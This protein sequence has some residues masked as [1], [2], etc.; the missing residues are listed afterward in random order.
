M[1][2]AILTN[3]ADSFQKPMAEG[4]SRMFSQIGVESLILYDGLESLPRLDMPGQTEQA[5][6]KDHVRRVPQKYNSWVAYRRLIHILRE[7]DFAVIVSHVPIPYMEHF[8]DDMRLRQDVPELPIVLYDLVYLPTRGNWAKWILENNPIRVQHGSHWGL[9]RYDYH[10]C[11]TEISPLPVPPG[12]EAF[13][14]IGIN[15]ADPSLFVEPNKP[16]VALIDFERPD[17]LYER[18]VQILAC[19][20]AGIPFKV[21]HG[22]YPMDQIRAIY[23]SCSV[24]F[25]A[26]HESFG[27]PICEVQACGAAVLTP[28]A[29]WCPS[30]CLARPERDNW[31]LPRNFVVYDNDLGKLVSELERLKREHK[32]EE[33]LTRF[34]QDQ[35]HFYFGDLDELQRFVHL[36]ENGT[37][38]STSHNAY[39]TLSELVRSIGK[40]D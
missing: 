3:R 1:K 19:V 18:A 4:L 21:L 16:V 31:K 11:V 30:H 7:V 32:A 29:H 35:S 36:I 10:L 25:L 38:N 15:L 2:T 37:V 14:R 39:P 13:A 17:H 8:F 5:D 22:H 34:K 33:V 6:W 24:Y 26:W 28:Y 23:R 40:P 12:A 9:N 27:L 20:K